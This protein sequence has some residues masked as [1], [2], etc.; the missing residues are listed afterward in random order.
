MA[1]KLTTNP[2]QLDTPGATSVITAD[3]E[4]T[5]IIVVPN[6]AAWECVLHDEASGNV[7]FQA[8]NNLTNDDKAFVW[9]PA[10]PYFATGIY[11]TT[12]T[13]VALVLIYT[14]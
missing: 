13:N 2:I 11:Y 14:G 12:G 4:I 9:S 3:H 1:N 6:A 5:S 7:I 8:S 10:K